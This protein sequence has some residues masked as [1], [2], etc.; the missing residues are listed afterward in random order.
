MNMASVGFATR[1]A[2]IENIE[3]FASNVAS[4]FMQEFDA[5]RASAAEGSHIRC[6][7]CLKVIER[8]EVCDLTLRHTSQP[9]EYYLA[10]SCPHC[11]KGLGVDIKPITSM[12]YRLPF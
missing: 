7:E 11:E 2:S 8:V 10:F 6:P 12:A 1:N 4:M 9:A 5:L 3:A